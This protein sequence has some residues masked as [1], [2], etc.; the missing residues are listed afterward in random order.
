MYHIHM[1]SPTFHNTEYMA[2]TGG[3]IIKQWLIIYTHPDTRQKFVKLK[4]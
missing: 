2:R 4:S 1:L 3:I